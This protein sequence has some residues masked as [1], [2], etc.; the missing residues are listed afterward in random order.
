MLQ[1]AAK[2]GEELR[3]ETLKCSKTYKLEEQVLMHLTKSGEAQTIVDCDFARAR[4]PDRLSVKPLYLHVKCE[5][6]SV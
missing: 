5:L 6:E 3:L 1:D 4:Q 2:T